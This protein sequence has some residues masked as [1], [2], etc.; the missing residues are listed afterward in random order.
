MQQSWRTDHDKLTFIICLPL[1]EDHDPSGVLTA[2][3]HD[4]GERMV[5][6]I[7]LFLFPVDD[8]DD[9]DTS[10]AENGS[11]AG[12][13]K[14]IGEIELM[15]APT[16]LRR[17]GFGRAALVTF[18]VYVLSNW[19]AIAKEYSAGSSA[20]DGLPQLDHLRARINETNERSIALFESVDFTKVSET[21]NYF[22]EVELR[23]SGSVDEAKGFR[24]WAEPCVLKYQE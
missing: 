6:D 1:P 18:I 8:D 12:T 13:T 21:A 3:L 7:N 17:Q 24:G 20:D 9:D 11:K 10:G 2:G 14:A 19:S 15:I 4:D 23:W 5:G 22:G 16:N